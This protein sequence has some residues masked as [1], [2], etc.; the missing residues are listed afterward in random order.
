[1]VQ[2]QPRAER[3]AEGGCSRECVEL[4]WQTREEDLAH[5]ALPFSAVSLMLLV[6]RYY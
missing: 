6:T 5:L 1:M 3:R 2:G 4:R